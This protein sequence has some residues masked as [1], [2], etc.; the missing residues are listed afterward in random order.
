M[1]SSKKDMLMTRHSQPEKLPSILIRS[2][3]MPAASRYVDWEWFV[4]GLR[5]IYGVGG[6]LYKMMEVSETSKASRC[7][8]IWIYPWKWSDSGWL[9][10]GTEQ[11]YG[12]I[13]LDW[14]NKVQFLFNIPH[15][16]GFDKA[17]GL[18]IY[19]SKNG[20]KQLIV[21]YDS[22]A[23]ERRFNANS[24]MRMCLRWGETGFLRD[25]RLNFTLW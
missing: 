15:A 20:K 3:W 22:P 19:D 2:I 11:W 14:R 9:Y 1:H 8:T 18:K 12:F 13:S 17:E 10:L 6:S 21:V 24:V 25:R 5:W 4:A 16:D 7:W 23:A